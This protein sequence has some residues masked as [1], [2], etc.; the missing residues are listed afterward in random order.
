LFPLT[1]QVI[2]RTGAREPQRRAAQA[3]CPE[4]APHYSILE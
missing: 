1:L 4:R 2:A 3:V